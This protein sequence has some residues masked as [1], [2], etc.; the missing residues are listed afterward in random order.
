MASV[1]EQIQANADRNRTLLSVLRETDN[2]IPD[3]KQQ[4]RFI[5]DLESQLKQINAA[6]AELERR[7]TRDQK[8]HEKYRD[9]VMRRF[10]Y[11][12]S[13]QRE[14]FEE[15]AEVGE[16]EYL[17]GL[18]Q[19]QE[20]EEVKRELENVLGEA[21]AG[22]GGLEK[23]AQRHREAQND[24]DHMY[25]S[26]FQGPSPDFPKEDEA[27]QRAERALQ[28]YHDMRIRLDG[29]QQA[30]GLLNHAGALLRNALRNMDTARSYSNWDMWGGGTM[31]SMMKRNELGDAERNYMSARTLVVQAQRTGEG[32]PDLPPVK[33][34]AGNILGD[35][36][37]DNVFS[38]MDFHA[39]I[40]QM[41]L[42]MNHCESWIRNVQAHVKGTIGSL[43]QELG[44]RAR[45]LEDSR[46]ALQATRA[47]VF[48]RLGQ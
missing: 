11:K 34:A 7:R 15:K 3:L 43:D 10:A 42:E 31:S 16:R 19:T 30:L 21:Q 27:E 13:G 8:Q 41:Q 37:F 5:S 47:A 35:V 26:I 20:K 44:G 39:K 46:V 17:D 36:I 4:E 28:A 29:E 40:K 22:R 9:S 38:D 14:K 6:L 23:D 1:R 12:V 48:E 33:I 45:E 2:A 25:D 24:L 18:Q 32:I